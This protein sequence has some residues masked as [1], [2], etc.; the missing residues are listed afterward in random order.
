[1][2][3]ILATTEPQKIPMTI[4]SRCQ[5]F[6]FKRISLRA[7]IERMK[8][9]V[10]Q[11][12]LQVEEEALRLIAQIAQGG[13]RDALSLLDQTISFAGGL[14]KPEHVMSVV[15]KTSIHE[16]GTIITYIHSGKMKEVLTAVETIIE[17]GKE[18]DLFLDDLIGYYR[19]L[20]LYQLSYD[21][22][23]LSTAIMN[24]SFLALS[25]SLHIEIIQKGIQELM[26]QKSI[27]KWSNSAKTALE[28]AM[29]KLLMLNSEP[30]LPSMSIKPQNEGRDVPSKQV[31]QDEMF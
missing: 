8:F 11:E 26:E 22:T 6:D 3:F 16:I 5:R 17:A 19:D 27:L 14:V 9:I 1:M 20:L 31:M 24:D 18:P 13:M 7:M 10:T 28:V 23:Q 12:Q 25:Q 30:Q 15:G 2:I 29:V 4:I 21:E